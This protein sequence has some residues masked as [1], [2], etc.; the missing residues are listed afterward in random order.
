MTELQVSEPRPVPAAPIVDRPVFLVAAPRAGRWLFLALLEHRLP[1][2]LPRVV[3]ADTVDGM[4]GFRLRD[5]DFKSHR[6]TDADLTEE[7]RQV[8][9]SAYALAAGISTERTP[10][11]GEATA[12][13]QELL[14]DVRGEQSL[15][16]P[17]LFAAFPGARFILLHRDPRQSVHAIGQAWKDGGSVTVPELPGWPRGSWSF[18]LPEDWRNLRNASLSDIAAFQWRA[19]NEQLLDDFECLP[20]HAWTSVDFS[21]LSSN[22]DSV[23]ARI[24]GFLGCD[25]PVDGRGDVGRTRG[26]V[27]DSI[28]VPSPIEWRE[29]TDLLLP[30]LRSL[31]PI[32][33]RLRHLTAH[34][35]ARARSTRP[36]TP[37]RYSCFLDD[38]ARDFPG[39]SI[40]AGRQ[41]L[42]PFCR[43]QIG[44]SLPLELVRRGR[45]RERFLEDHP[46]VWIDDPTTG[47][48][49][50]Y[51]ARRSHGWQ[52]AR[53]H[54][55]LPLPENFD[56]ELARGLSIA[57]ALV[58]TGQPAADLSS[59]EQSIARA[60]EELRRDQYC[61]L[62][63]PLPM[64]QVAALAA[65]Y[66]TL[67][68]SGTWELGDPQ[69]ER[70]YGC[71]N[72]PISRFF[73]SQ[74]TSLISRVAG[75]PLKPTYSYCSA[76]Q[77]GADLGVH[78]DREQCDF[79]VSLLI[80]HSSGLAEHPWP[81]WFL[82]PA[83]RVS[84]TLGLGEAVLFRGA[85]LPHWRD[86]A[87]LGQHQVMLLFHF[88]PI[89]FAGTR[90]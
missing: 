24:A 67:T 74:I 44:A 58:E 51:W 25:S 88:V 17:F 77:G 89:Y 3:R 63:P 21:D 53:V 8:M 5:R 36:S 82:A 15:R 26:W 16:V 90:D 85:D 33:G 35:T 22:P 50:P 79:T 10:R 20:R 48:L 84:L 64:M 56:P 70:R 12:N 28:F 1:G 37:A 40:V 42:A 81:L 73:H 71:H 11:R 59:G 18:A 65:Y 68:G 47:V 83:G 52:L 19:V 41:S 46:I 72:E 32:N 45:F 31:G 78:M 76:Y 7:A 4:A 30:S 69:V 6:L 49:N 57:G 87:P 27:E 54:P 62:P 43:T 60:R 75:E 39:E 34:R 66:R 9:R 14:F 86:P 80:D 2:I 38:L 55:G 13:R 23:A 61:I 29:G